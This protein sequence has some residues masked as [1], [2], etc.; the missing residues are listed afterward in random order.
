MIIARI[1]V[2]QAGFVPPIAFHSDGALPIS[3][4]H[5]TIQIFNRNPIILTMMNIYT[6]CSIENGVGKARAF[7]QILFIGLIA[8]YIVS[9][10][11]D[12]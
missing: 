1:I 8:C 5:I 3:G 12:A 2:I 10:F 7:Q 4:V 11:P 6:I 9:G